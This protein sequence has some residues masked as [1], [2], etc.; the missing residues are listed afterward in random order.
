[1]ITFEE[2][3]EAINSTLGPNK[4]LVL[5]RGIKST[6]VVKVFKVFF[7]DL[8]LVNGDKPE[9]VLRVTFIE[10]ADFF[11]LQEVQKYCDKKY[12][13][14]L[15]LWIASEKFKQLRDATV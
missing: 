6:S 3:I 5:H 4:T 14:Q 13:K 1:M 8:Y 11:A 15:M 10:R 9:S 7:Y 2:L 12:L